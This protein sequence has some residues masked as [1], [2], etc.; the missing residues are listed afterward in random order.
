MKATVMVCHVCLM[1]CGISAVCHMCHGYKV[2]YSQCKYDECT[3]NVMEREKKEGKGRNR[4]R[5]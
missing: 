1:S 4:E 3:K 5:G 2:E